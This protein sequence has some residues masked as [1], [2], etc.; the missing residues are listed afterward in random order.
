VH[1][2]TVLVG[3]EAEDDRRR[4]HQ[5]LQAFL[6]YAPSEPSVGASPVLGEEE[7]ALPEMA[8]G[9]RAGR[10]PGGALSAGK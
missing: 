10:P 7:R 5:T 6:T 4:V 3:V 8:T 2:L 9:W 1:S